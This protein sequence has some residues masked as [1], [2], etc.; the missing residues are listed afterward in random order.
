M[1]VLIFNDVKQYEMLYEGLLTVTTKGAETRTLSK[2]LAKLERV[3]VKREVNGKESL[4]YTLAETRPVKFEDS[5]FSFIKT[6]L[7]EVEWSGVGAKL[8]GALLE[9]LDE[10]HPT[11]EEFEARK[12]GILKIAKDG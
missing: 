9:W 12:D 5:E 3:G 7:N 4:L 6:K 10:K 1:R 11:E 2:V 8:A